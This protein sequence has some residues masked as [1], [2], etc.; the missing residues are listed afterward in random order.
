MEMYWKIGNW[1]LG[2]NG[3]GSGMGLSVVVTYRLLWVFTLLD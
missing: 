3:R 2:I 1:E